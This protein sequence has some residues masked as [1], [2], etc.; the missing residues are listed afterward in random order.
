MFRKQHPSYAVRVS[1]DS[2]YQ[3]PA[4]ILLHSTS[5]LFSLESNFVKQVEEFPLKDPHRFMLPSL[6]I[7]G[8]TFSLI[9]LFPSDVFVKALLL[10]FNPMNETG[11]AFGLSSLTFSFPFP[12]IGMQVCLLPYTI[13]LSKNFKC[14]LNHCADPGRHQAIGLEPQC[15]ALCEMTLAHPTIVKNLR[16]KLLGFRSGFYYL[17]TK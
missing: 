8:T 12:P 7:N 11:G 13:L 3:G 5:L 17:P 16:A 9:F 2:F 1:F 6:F 4:W 15:F 14:F 10:P